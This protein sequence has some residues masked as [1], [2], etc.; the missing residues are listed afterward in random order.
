MAAASGSLLCGRRGRWRE[1]RACSFCPAVVAQSDS[2]RQRPPAQPLTPPRLAPR[3]THP[4]PCSDLNLEFEIPFRELG[5]HGVPA[6]SS[7]FIMPTVNCLV[8]LTEM[9]F[10]VLTLAGER[11]RRGGGFGGARRAWVAGRGEGAGAA[12][13]GQ[14]VCWEPVAAGLWGPA[15]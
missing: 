3:H 5:F 1:G 12:E 14:P 6:R 4:P 7:A 9:P 10:T 8:E 15:P 11:G 2:T 13:I